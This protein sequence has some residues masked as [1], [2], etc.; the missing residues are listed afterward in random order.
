MTIFRGAGK[1]SLTAIFVAWVLSVDPD[2][3][4]LVL[5]AESAL[6]RKL[7]RNTKRILEK[8]PLTTHLTPTKPDQWASDRLTVNRTKELRD[9]SLLAK[10]IT[11][12]ITGA[13][14]DIIIC[15][16]V[17][18][19]N[20]CDTAQKRADLRTRLAELDFIVTPDGT[21]LYLGT[22]HT[23]FSIYADTPRT[24]IDEQ[25]PFL[26]GYDRLKI[27]V[28]DE[29]GNSVWPQRFSAEHI[30]EQK[31]TSGPNAFASQ[32]MLTPVNILQGR[33][34]PALLR[35]YGAD[36]HYSE[37]Q[38]QVQLRLCGRKIVSA[39]A[40][41]DPAF[42][43][44]SGDHSVLA[45]V[46]TD[47]EGEYWL[48]HLEYLQVVEGGEDEATQQCRAIVKLAQDY[49]LPSI[50]VE[51]NGI[52]RFLPSILRREISQARL[53]CAI[54]EKTST[55]SKDI[56]ILE[57]FDAVMAARA[58]HI[59]KRVLQTP[60][61]TEMQE[62]RPGTSKSHDDGLDA[63]AG[64]LSLEPVRIKRSYPSKFVKSWRSDAHTANTD[65]E[66]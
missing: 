25:E 61:V 17:E 48:H 35:P 29:N 2:L 56:R 28:L 63:V 27:P 51:T 6:A 13:R 53:P 54:I 4:I 64:A 49:Y 22:P 58:L 3:R 46:Y 52:G 23:W 12:N 66:V 34:D 31:R 40:W 19:P 11:S 41:W 33:L 60:F 15:D 45:I 59:H 9:P 1:S 47:E 57:S 39:S 43:S 38:V 7:V 10:G 5:S 65:F 8:H 32:M 24:E 36:L 21:L 37:A 26:D 14:A 42:G 18:V 62:W 44:T 20:T 50:A 30:E 16:D 55:R